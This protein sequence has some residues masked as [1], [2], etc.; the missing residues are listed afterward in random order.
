MLEHEPADLATEH[1]GCDAPTAA[2]SGDAPLER[3]DDVLHALVDLVYVERALAQEDRDAQLELVAL[4][5]ADTAEGLRLEHR[6][7]RSAAP[8]I[9]WWSV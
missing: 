7:V 8:L 3:V 9:A 2:P 4:P 6:G 1:D 5:V